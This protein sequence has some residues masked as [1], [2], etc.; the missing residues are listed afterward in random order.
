LTPLY[1]TAIKPINPVNSF[2]KLLVTG[3]KQNLC[4]TFAFT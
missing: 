1:S 3:K 4:Y 2:S